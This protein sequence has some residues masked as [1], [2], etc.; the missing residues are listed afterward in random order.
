MVLFNLILEDVLIQEKN[1]QLS[2]ESSAPSR[3]IRQAP[4]DPKDYLDEEINFLIKT[5]PL[6]IEKAKKEI[7]SGQ[8]FKVILCNHWQLFQSES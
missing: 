5:I 4:G 6:T 3:H 7:E 2:L 1:C 8:R